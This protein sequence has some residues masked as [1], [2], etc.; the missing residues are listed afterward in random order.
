MRAPVLVF[1]LYLKG[2]GFRISC[3]WNGLFVCMNFFLYV[4]LA[5][6]A[7]AVEYANNISTEG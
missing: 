4:I 6:S 7:G 2:S 3:D 5:L 1:L